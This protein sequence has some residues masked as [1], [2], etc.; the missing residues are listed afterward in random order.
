MAG[1]PTRA[2]TEI[3]CFTKRRSRANSGPERPNYQSFLLALGSAPPSAMGVKKP[4]STVSTKRQRQHRDGGEKARPRGH[5]QAT[6]PGP[7]FRAPSS[8]PTRILRALR[9]EQ[10]LAWGLQPALARTWL[11]WPA[12]WPSPERRVGFTLPCCNPWR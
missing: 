11:L 6:R 4:I 3:S 2:E 12:G 1:A 5:A 10:P 8:P 7:D 9:G